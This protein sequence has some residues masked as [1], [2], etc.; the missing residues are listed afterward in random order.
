MRTQRGGLSPNY[1][2]HPLW[3]VSKN[4]ASNERLPLDKII[5]K[6]SSFVTSGANVGAL[7]NRGLNAVHHL[8]EVEVTSAAAGSGMRLKATYDNAEMLGL[9]AA[10]GVDAAVPVD[11]NGSRSALQMAEEAGAEKL[12]RNSIG[13]LNFRCKSGTS[14][15]TTSL[16]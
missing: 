13:I 4:P 2:C 8:V 1:C 9:L 10:A 6:G 12:G 11:G 7:D 16:D 3:I 15:G 5:R 14:S